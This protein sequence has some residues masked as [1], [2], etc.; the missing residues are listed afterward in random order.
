MLLFLICGFSGVARAYEVTAEQ[1]CFDTVF[2]SEPLTV[3]AVCYRPDVE[4]DLPLLVMVHGGTYGKWL[5]D[6]PGASW[7]AYLTRERGYPMLAVD[8]P[9]YGESGHPCGDV[10]TPLAYGRVLTQVL[11]AVR[12]RTDRQVVYI[13]HS[14]GA[15]TGNLIAGSGAG[16]VDGL[17][18]LGW[19]HYDNPFNESDVGLF[20]MEDYFF[21]PTEA[22]RSLMYFEPG[23]EASVMAFDM[24]HAHRF[25]RGNMWYK[26]QTD[27]GVLHRI[28]VPVFLSLGEHDYL[29]GD[30]S[31]DAEKALFTGSPAVETYL[32]PD[33]GHTSMLHKNYRCLLD[34]LDAWI[35]EE[36]V[37]R[38]V[39]PKTEEE[40]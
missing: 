30:Y 3:S 18:T 2:L 23:A 32:Q 35:Q 14:I 40:R 20:E 4:G 15:M 12:T 7:M 8:L 27:K 22:R 10:M 37:P 26:L 17:V 1:I 38:A 33:A 16:L 29:R 25:A 39:G 34:R 13:G 24:A 19:A 31:M 21:I 9:G 6:V 5:W 28:T 36:V 11:A